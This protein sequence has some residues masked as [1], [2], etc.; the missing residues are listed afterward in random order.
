MVPEAACAAV[1]AG[2]APHTD[3]RHEAFLYRG[4]DE[5]MAGTLPFIRSAVAAREPILVVLGAERIAA[6]G[7]AL[8]ADRARV[9][10]AD[11]AQVGA[12]PAHIIPA[13]Q[14]FLDAHA[15]AGRRVWGI[16]EP[17]WAGRGAAELAECQRHEALLNVAFASPA[18]SLLC[19]Y[20]T[21][22]LAPGVIAE[23]CRTHAFVSRHGS[24]ARS[25]ESFAG[26]AAFALPDTAPLP[27]RPL[28]AARRRFD[29]RELREVRSWVAARA[30]DAGLPAARLEDLRLAFNEVAT[31]SIRHGG[32]GGRVSVWRDRD[33]VVCE[34]RDAG[35][36]EDP[37]A[38]RR[39]PQP[40]VPGGRGLWIA[41]Q[42]TDLVQIRMRGGG[43]VVRIHVRGARP[44]DR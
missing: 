3:F 35:R 8:G 23:A 5:F 2:H 18:F 22:T 27:R 28:R 20:D 37:L 38:G 44:A 25:S 17:I 32:G 6:L 19:P 12:N 36:V 16:G 13:W 34:V 21:G 40:Q 31:N 24:I 4:E 33:A 15:H 7:A 29:A 1:P 11:M 43:C 10:F 41:N 42:A 9:L 39:C 14:R 26:A 30:A